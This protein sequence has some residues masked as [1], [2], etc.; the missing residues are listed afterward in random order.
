MKIIYAITLKASASK[1]I[2][3]HNHPSGKL[4]PSPQDKAITNKAVECGNFLDITICD[5][6][7]VT[8]HTYLSLK[9]EGYF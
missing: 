7:I 8:P 1:I 5:H 9:D 6:L 3:V 2:L 4:E